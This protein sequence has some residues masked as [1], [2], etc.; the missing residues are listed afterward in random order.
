MKQVFLIALLWGMSLVSGVN[1]TFVLK[2]FD[3]EEVT[4]FL[5]D[6]ASKEE[7]KKF[8]ESLRLLQEEINRVS[9]LLAEPLQPLSEEDEKEIEEELKRI[10][11]EIQ[12]E[13]AQKKP[14]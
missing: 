11:E 7:Q 9:Q 10:E 12:L 4:I 3:G 14:L 13:R 6:D 1:K 8:K 5:P 2:D